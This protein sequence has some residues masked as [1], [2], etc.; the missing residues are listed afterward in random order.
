MEI[1]GIDL[2]LIAPLLIIQL[3]LVIVAIID[4]V[5]VKETNGPKW[6]WLIIII[7]INIIGPVLYFIFGRRQ[8]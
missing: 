8:R 1:A 4:W 3:I 7:V 6:L 2:A 5:K